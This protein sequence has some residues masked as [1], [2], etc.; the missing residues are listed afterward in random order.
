MTPRIS[1]TEPLWL[2]WAVPRALDP[3]IVAA[4]QHTGDYGPSSKSEI[5]PWYDGTEAHH[6]CESGLEDGQDRRRF[7]LPCPGPTANATLLRAS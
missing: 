5:C 3:A 6:R 4:A 1:E 2:K 7:V